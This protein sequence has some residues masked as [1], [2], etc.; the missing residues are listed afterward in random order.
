MNQRTLPALPIVAGLIIVLTAAWIG[1]RMLAEPDETEGPESTDVAAASDVT[2]LESAAEVEEDS[3]L[4][5]P[6]PADEERRQVETEASGS[7]V[8][9]APAD[10]VWMEG[11]VRFPVGTPDDER[12]FVIALSEARTMRRLYGTGLAGYA[13]GEEP[14]KRDDFL[15]SALVDAQGRFRLALP[16]GTDHTHLALTG[17]YLYSKA[18]TPVDVAAAA[19]DTILTGEIGSWIT[20][21][22]LAPD[23]ATPEEA[24][25]DE[26]EVE[27]GPDISSGFNTMEM[28]ASGGTREVE[29]LSDGLFEFRGVPGSIAHGISVKHDHLA[30][31][32]LLGVAPAPGEHL[33][34]DVPMTRGAT[35]RG[36][37]VDANGAAIAEAKVA[38]RFRGLLGDALGDLRK[39]ETDGDGRWELANVPTGRKLDVRAN[40]KGHLGGRLKLDEE[41]R[42]GDVIANL[43][44]T[45]ETGAAITGRVT[46]A[47]GATATGVRVTV[48]PDMSQMG[49]MDGMAIARARGGSEE[50]GADGTFTIAGLTDIKFQVRA[51]HDVEE[52]EHAGKWKATTAGVRPG[53][54]PLVLTLQQLSVLRGRVVDLAE[55]PVADFKVVA[56]LEGSGG[57]FGIGATRNRNTFKAAEDGAFELG[58]LDAGTWKLVV[59]AAGFA[60]SDPV[61]VDTPRDESAGPVQIT[62]SPSATVTGIVLDTADLPVA[63]AKVALQLGLAERMTSQQ[64]GGGPTAFTDSDGKFTLKDLN[65]GTLVVVASMDG[66][67]S[68]A[69][70]PVDVAAGQTI[71]DVTLRLRLGGSISGE[72]FDNEGVPSPG[73]MVIVQLTPTY[74]AQHMLQSDENGEFF[75]EH[76]E[77]G[78]WQ[79]VATANFMSGEADF[80][81]EGGGMAELL[82]S[83][84]MD[85]VEVFDGEETH[86][87]LGAPPEDPVELTITVLAAG[88]PIAKTA[89]S[90]VPEGGG[91]MSAMKMGVTNDDGRLELTLDAPGAYLVTVQMGLGGMGQ[92]SSTEF[93]EKIPSD[94]AE[95]E[96]VLELPLGRISGLV[97]GPN[98]KPVSNCRVTLTPEGGVAFGSFMGGQYSEITTDEEG[99]YDI[100]YLRAG[101]YTVCAG[102]T[103]LGGLLGG[104]GP[105]G[106]VV[107][108]GI[109][110]AEGEWVDAIDFRL[111]LPGELTGFVHDAS[112]APV[113]DV[114]VF[115]RDEEGRLLER[116]SFITTNA[117]GRFK[118]TGLAPGRYSVIGRL[119]ELVSPESALAR[120]NEG[121]TAEASVQLGPGTVVIVTV[122]DGTDEQIRARISVI[123]PAGREVSGM[124]SMADIMAGMSKGFSSKE[125]RIGPL[126][127]GKYRVTATTDD[128]RSSTKPV[129][130][131]GQPERKLKIRLK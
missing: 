40:R 79:V 23:G 96:F 97:R 106:R 82:G 37:V 99:R 114:A 2:R 120:V 68:S 101:T 63:N 77:P 91:G 57:M 26:V 115:I 48:S 103:P 122:I 78:T 39:S 15:G 25:F 117:S 51:R 44:V 80:G 3:A 92:Q 19:G 46:F 28:Q 20:G 76:L 119:G 111:E 64:A 62:L 29:T 81:G 83:M 110:L 98:A 126:P 8:L 94:K 70:E 93:L 49:G 72:V 108:D 73:R 69:A 71:G 58:G 41:P 18:T 109:E 102:G 116:F 56:T 84:K 22:L 74:T 105:G 124:L 32:L 128:G 34:L 66:F 16:A 45:L 95:H 53:S 42:E 60:Q 107:R 30:A 85:M 1:S 9:D 113:K 88:E 100:P 104:T 17:R 33:E 127:P 12:V 7:G 24:D 86:V 47:D 131:S 38:A 55:E 36:T 50:T 27:L 43:V 112:G 52:G 129:T 13:W 5:A 87:V 89:V 59:S 75:V 61:L 31:V 123:D 35:L 130:L 10:A 4:E 121:E 21:R 14:R 125:Q 67:A 118:Y 54:D 65:P 11:L 6:E 90:L